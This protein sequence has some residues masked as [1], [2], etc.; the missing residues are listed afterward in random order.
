M[1]DHLYLA[2]HGIKG[3][4][5]GVRRFRNEDGTLTDEGRRR[6]YDKDGNLTPEAQKLNRDV[7]NAQKAISSSREVV[8]N[9]KRVVD[10][11]VKYENRYERKP[12]TQ[13]ELDSMSNAELEYLINRIGLERKYSQI[14]SDD[15][16]QDRVRRGLDYA[17]AVLSVAGSALGVAVAIKMLQG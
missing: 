7:A 3:M 13:E 11:S 17:D 9:A 8:S 1:E 12:L 6:Y 10:S 2:H 15:T 5:W 16:A 4:K 14:T